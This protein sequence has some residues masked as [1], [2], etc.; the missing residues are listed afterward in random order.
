LS[1]VGR[2]F[3][4][5]GRLL[6]QGYLLTDDWW[7]LAT[8]AFILLHIFG[9][10]AEAFFGRWCPARRC[11]HHGARELCGDISVIRKLGCFRTQSAPCSGGRTQRLTTQ[12]AQQQV[13]PLFQDIVV[14]RMLGS[15]LDTVVVRVLGHV[16]GLSTP[17]W[18]GARYGKHLGRRVC[19]W[20]TA[21]K[22]FSHHGYVATWQHCR[23]QVVGVLCDILDILFPGG[24]AVRRTPLEIQWRPQG[25]SFVII[26]LDY[27][28]TL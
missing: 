21:F 20:V 7:C 8:L 5:T 15:F 12:G 17:L 10:A 14:I 25:D 1:L 13:G 22:H 23:L 27:L 28:R 18:A 4:H 9:S 3:L 24:R 2:W 19:A 16:A 6:L 26:T 11:D